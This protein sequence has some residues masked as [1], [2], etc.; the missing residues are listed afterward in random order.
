MRRTGRQLT[1]N[2]T[3]YCSLSRPEFFHPWQSGWS[4]AWFR[5]RRDPLLPASATAG[6][7]LRKGHAQCEWEAQVDIAERRRSRHAIG[8]HG[9]NA[10]GLRLS[11]LGLLSFLA[12]SMHRWRPLAPLR[13]VSALDSRF[14]EVGG[15]GDCRALGKARAETWSRVG[16]LGRAGTAVGRG[17]RWAPCAAAARAVVG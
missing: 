17:V 15:D 6:W 3:W 13:R 11:R 14:A 5:P 16:R 10:M 12:R 1:A 7:Y 9:G 8:P 2:W 4:R